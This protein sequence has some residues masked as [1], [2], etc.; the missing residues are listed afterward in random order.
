MRVCERA[1]YAY[2]Y[3]NVQHMMSAGPGCSGKAGT[4]NF[5]DTG[6]EKVLKSDMVKDKAEAAGIRE[7]GNRPPS[8]PDGLLIA[9]QCTHGSPP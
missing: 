6:L 8:Q 4:G 2:T 1:V 9:Y 7:P 3:V 5:L